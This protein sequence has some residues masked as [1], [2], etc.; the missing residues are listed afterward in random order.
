MRRLIPRSFVFV[1]T[2]ALSAAGAPARALAQ[3]TPADVARDLAALRQ[4]VDRLR[5]EIDALKGVAPAPVDAEPSTAAALEVVKAQVAELA[6]VKVES[7]SR[8][9]VRI[10]GVIHTHLFANSG[11]GNWLENP[12]LVDAPL[13]DGGGGTFSGTLRQTRLGF[14]IDGPTL[15]SARTSGVVAMDFFGGM[16]G[17]Q[18]GQVMGLPRLLVA[19]ARVEGKK[20]S[21]EVGQDH[22]ILAPRDPTSLAAFSF[23]LL[24]RSGNLYLRAPQVRL[25]RA[26]TSRLR[27]I[28]GIVAPIGGD[29]TGS[30]YRFVPPALGGERS[31]RPAVQARVLYQTGDCTSTRFLGAGVSGHYG[32]ERRGGRLDR[33]WAAAIDFGGRRDRVGVAGELYVGDNADAFGGASGLDRRAA[34]G[35]AELQVFAHPR[36][37]FHTGVGLDDVRDAD[38]AA[39]VRRGNR[40]AFGNVLFTLTP[41]IQASL[42]YRWMSTRPGA[43]D[44]RTNH[45]VDWVMTYKF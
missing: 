2:L 13:P 1:L 38:R 41:E 21:L 35:W 7:E 27:V 11:S 12:N 22:V 6:Q 20:T 5:R 24:F 36:V 39:L 9:P 29:L 16:P 8:M 15:G 45:H 33:S 30:D 25:E 28:G 18:T 37:S 26:L 44:A 10:F 4:E 32:W 23:P 17:F 19:Y 14:A 31:M 43:G 42:E 40:T 3:D 34:G